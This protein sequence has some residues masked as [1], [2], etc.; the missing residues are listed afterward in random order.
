[1]IFASAYQLAN[2]VGHFCVVDFRVCV[3]VQHIECKALG[4]AER[5]TVIGSSVTMVI[6]GRSSMSKVV[7]VMLMNRKSS[8]LSL[9][10]S[11]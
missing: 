11:G 4:A 5:Q 10:N 7:L 9:R 3:V 6:L 8:P 1:M 2:D